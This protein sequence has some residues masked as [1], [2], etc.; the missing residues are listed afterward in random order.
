MNP[1]QKPRARRAFTLVEML[2]VLA[3]LGILSGFLFAAFAGVREKGRQT[4]CAS[5][6][7]QIGI[8]FSLYADDNA[9]V[10]PPSSVE[11][12]R[13]VW[14][15]E[16]TAPYVKN[17]QIYLCPSDSSSKLQPGISVSSY[18]YN[19]HIGGG[20]DASFIDPSPITELYT[21]VQI[22][23]PS[24]TVMMAES[25]TTA[26]VGLPPSQWPVV[27][28]PF[29]MIGD[30]F[31][32]WKLWPTKPATAVL[33]APNPRHQGRVNILWADGHVSALPIPAF[34]NSPEHKRPQD[35]LPGLSPCF[36]P[37]MGCD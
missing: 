35:K 24:A 12:S 2:V 19:Q 32:Q 34:Y 29:L 21:N 37:D 23:R 18:G 9:D 1:T 31:R 30:A 20:L 10:L 28:P 13:N 14:W 5:N 8:A 16:L 11:V 7:K 27:E 33:T 6:L 4:T 36:R 25:G 22:V 17:Q 26:T 15:P 3:I